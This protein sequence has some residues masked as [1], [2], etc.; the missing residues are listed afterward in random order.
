MQDVGKQ[1]FH[2]LRLVNGDEVIGIVD[3]LDARLGPPLAETDCHL[4][5]IVEESSRTGSP[6]ARCLTVKPL[7]TAPIAPLLL[8]ARARTPVSKAS[9]A[10][11]D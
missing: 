9:I 10:G 5:P 4:R 6:S 11:R 2:D 7:P 8:R 1:L 3:D